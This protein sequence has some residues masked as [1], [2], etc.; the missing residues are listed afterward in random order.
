M[1]QY[2]NGARTPKEKL[3]IDFANLL[4]FSQHALTVPNI[5]TDIGLMHTLLTLEDL[6]GLNRR[7]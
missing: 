3:V 2:E 7:D 5:D 6:Y 1:V 4:D